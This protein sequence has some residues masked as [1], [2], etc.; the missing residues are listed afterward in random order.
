MDEF[1]ED[2]CVPSI[3]EG[4]ISNIRDDA[5]STRKVKSKLYNDGFRIGKSSE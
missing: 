3:Y 1:G 4:N 5:S 2:K